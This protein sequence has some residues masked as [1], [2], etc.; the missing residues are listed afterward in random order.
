VKLQRAIVSII[1]IL[2]TVQLSYSD[3][4][5]SEV[6]SKFGV[7]DSKSEC[8]CGSELKSIAITLPSGL[9]LVG[10][11]R[12]RTIKGKPIDLRKSKITYDNYVDGNYP[13]G[14]LLIGGDIKMSGNVVSQDGGI[15]FEPN[16]PVGEKKYLITKLLGQRFYFPDGLSGKKFSAPNA[17]GEDCAMKGAN[18]EVNGIRLVLA[19]TDN[20]GSYALKYKLKFTGGM[21]KCS[22]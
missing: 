12:L 6:V 5:S 22:Y 15:Y 1:V 14:M 3:E 17:F 18:V 7:E 19:D 16:R 20:E 11:C 21:K 10:A 13:D 4:C 8:V 9:K 2:G